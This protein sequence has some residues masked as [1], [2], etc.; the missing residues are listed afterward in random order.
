MNTVVQYIVRD[1]TVVKVKKWVKWTIR[2]VYMWWIDQFFRYQTADTSTADNHE[3]YRVSKV[4]P[5]QTFS[6]VQDFLWARYVSV[7]CWCCIPSPFPM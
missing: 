6:H 5:G 7:G 2:A 4:E 1:L 3:K